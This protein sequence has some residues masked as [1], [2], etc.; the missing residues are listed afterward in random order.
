MRQRH[1]HAGENLHV[2]RLATSVAGVGKNHRIE[3]GQVELVVVGRF[4]V[5]NHPRSE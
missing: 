3:A 2:A 5:R 1:E 4:W